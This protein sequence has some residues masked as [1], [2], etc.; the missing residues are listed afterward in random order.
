LLIWILLSL[1]VCTQLF[2]QSIILIDDEIHHCFTEPQTQFWVSQQQINQV[3]EGTIIELDNSI[4]SKGR[5]ISKL[6][7]ENVWQDSVI[8]ALNKIIS[9]QDTVKVI[10]ER[11]QNLDERQLKK[12]RRKEKLEKAWKIWLRPTMIALGTGLIGYGLGSVPK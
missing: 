3:H 12:L 7:A 6:E 11:I 5:E 9:V 8:L 1:G 4:K 2:S 10:D